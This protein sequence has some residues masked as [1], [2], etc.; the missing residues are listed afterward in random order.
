MPD[1]N[2]YRDAAH[3]LRRLASEL[4]DA[5]VKLR[6][7]TE[8]SS[9]AGGPLVFVLTDAA[10]TYERGVAS[11]VEEMGRLAAI[12]DRRAEECE[13][14]ASAR[15]RGIHLAGDVARWLPASVPPPVWFRATHDLW[16]DG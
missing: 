14:T 13:R 7:V 12:C 16:A 2:D 3:R 11:A 1:A 15:Q 10:A 4:R 6:Q 9:F 5:P 8:P